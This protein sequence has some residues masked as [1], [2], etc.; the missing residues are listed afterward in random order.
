MGKISIL[1]NIWIVHIIIVLIIIYIW[2]HRSIINCLICIH[3]IINVEISGTQWMLFRVLNQLWIMIKLIW[4]HF[5]LIV[6][7]LFLSDLI[8]HISVIIIKFLNI[9]FI[10]FKLIHLLF[11]LMILIDNLDIYIFLLLLNYNLFDIFI[12]YCPIETHARLLIDLLLGQLRSICSFLKIWY[13]L[14][15]IIIQIFLI[16]Y[17]I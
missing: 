5:W 7:N 15:Q 6:R 14:I 4:I 9:I 8:T 3:L 10:I 17:D 1:F 12:R 2:L 16:I 13:L 11:L